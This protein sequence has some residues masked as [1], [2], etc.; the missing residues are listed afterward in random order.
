MNHFER[1]TATDPAI[2]EAIRHEETRQQHTLTL[3]ASENHT[4]PEV[5]A[6]NGSVL[7][8]KYAEGYPGRRYYAGQS[9]YDA[10]ERIAVD[11]AKAAFGAAHANV[12]PLSGSPM[13]QAVYFG[14]LDPGDTILA[15]DLTHGGHLTHGA[16]ASH[17]GRIFRFVRYKTH[18]PT[19]EI[20]FDE[21]RNL[22]LE[23][24]PRLVLCGH[25]SYPRE[26][27]YA[28]FK[29]IADE[30]GAYTMADVSHIGGLIAGGVLRN[31]L[32]DGFDVLTTTTHKT[33]RG[34]RGGLIACT[35]DL[36]VAIDKAVF[37]GLQGGPHMHQVAGIAVALGIALTDE[38]RRYARDV[39]G[40]ATALAEALVE[41]NVALITGGTENH[42]LVLDVTKAFDIDGAVA[43]E[44]LEAV[45][46][47]TN[48]QLIPDDPRPP[49]RPSG[50]RIGTPAVT[51][52]GLGVAEIQQV[53]DLIVRGLR[54]T[55]DA[56]VANEVQALASR[57]PVPGL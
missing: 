30:V 44:R 45:G 27:D 29:R 3:I 57:F 10:I 16:P 1:L 37:P 51:T 31:P 40:N 5:L 48:K 13:N 26:L 36:A 22:A 24:R 15:M 56:A 11:R 21:V 49:L 9:H 47:V 43:Q 7:T 20:D 35:R 52:R 54:A 12:Q 55:G 42:L 19:G 23:H 17:M 32:D 53:A 46:L 28:A 50:L 33:L 4:Y 38:F 39:L 6:A 2:A 34:S 8:D 41:S 18:G 25:S 14:L